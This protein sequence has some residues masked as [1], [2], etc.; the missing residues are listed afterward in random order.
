MLL[1]YIIS[2]SSSLIFPQITSSSDEL[3]TTTTTMMMTTTTTTTAAG[4]H[5]C[6]NQN[7]PYNVK[8]IRP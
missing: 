4:N 5:H 6:D 3:T 1:S 8:Y 7:C 2:V